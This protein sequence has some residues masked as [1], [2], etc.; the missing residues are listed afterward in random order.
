M[1]HDRE[2][3]FILL[4]RYFNNL[5]KLTNILTRKDS[6]QQVLFHF[7]RDMG[8]INIFSIKNL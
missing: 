1:I 3:D 2:K 7:S 6:V 4:D 8:S 5:A